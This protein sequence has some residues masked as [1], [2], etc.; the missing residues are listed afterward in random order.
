MKT[1][2]ILSI[3]LVLVISVTV[4]ITPASAE[5]AHNHGDVE[6]IFL[7]ENISEEL[8]E[9]ITDYILSGEYENGEDET[10]TY[11]VTCTLLGHKIEISKTHVIKHKVNATAPR[12][13]KQYVTIETCARCDYHN[14]TVTQA[15]FVNCCA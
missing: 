1:N 12:C 8:K 5:E 10:A 6:I 2:R 15:E 7:D 11:G 9:D 13:Y 14:S 4:F 3:L